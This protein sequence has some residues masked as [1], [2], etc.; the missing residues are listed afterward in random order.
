MPSINCM[1]KKEMEGNYRTK[2]VGI[3]M[4]THASMSKSTSLGAVRRLKILVSRNSGVA[5]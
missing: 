4:S 1:A 3:S 5:H 2:G